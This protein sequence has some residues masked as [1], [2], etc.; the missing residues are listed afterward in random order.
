MTLKAFFTIAAALIGAGAVAI[1]M[2]APN[3]MHH[4]GHMIHGGR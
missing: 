2:Y 3:L 1:H 4:F